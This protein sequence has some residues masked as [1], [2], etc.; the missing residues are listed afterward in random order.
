MS[1]PDNSAHSFTEG[2]DLDAEEIK[3]AHATAQSVRDA[4]CRDT[5]R[6]IYTAGMIVVHEERLKPGEIVM[7]CGDA[8]WAELQRIPKEAFDE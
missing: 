5:A 3:K 7:C 1:K 6:A 8:V 2:Y 4:C